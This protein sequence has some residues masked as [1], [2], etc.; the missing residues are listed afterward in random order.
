MTYF[1]HELNNKTF[2]ILFNSYKIYSLN[3]K[4][5]YIKII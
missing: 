4:K 3:I 5:D 2:F 1:I